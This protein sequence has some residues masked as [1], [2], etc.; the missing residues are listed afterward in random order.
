MYTSPTL[1][2]CRN[3]DRTRAGPSSTGSPPPLGGVRDPVVRR[4]LRQ[5]FV[6]HRK[7]DPARHGGRIE[8]GH[9]DRAGVQGLGTLDRRVQ[10]HRPD[11]RMV[12]SS[13]IVPKP[14]STQ[15]AVLQRV[16]VQKSEP[17]ATDPP[18]W[19]AKSIALR[20]NSSGCGAGIPR[21]GF[22]RN[23]VALQR[24]TTSKFGRMVVSG[25]L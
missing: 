18:G 16:V 14:D 7:A 1:V 13:A 17:Q 19:R 6:R 2:S 12:D 20:R 11:P 25:S 4:P 9:R 24:L 3:S 10:R 15:V 23:V 21:P 5:V 8:V 22:I